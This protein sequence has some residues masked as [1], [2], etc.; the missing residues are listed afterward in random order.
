MYYFYD[1]RKNYY[2]TKIT[3]IIYTYHIDPIVLYF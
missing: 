1:L 3:L 2:N